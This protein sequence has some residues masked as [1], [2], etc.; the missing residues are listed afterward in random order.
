ME[1][2][3]LQKV[4]ENAGGFAVL[5]DFYA[6]AEMYSLV[7]MRFHRHLDKSGRPYVE[8]CYHVANALR[9]YGMTLQA[10]GCGH[11]LIEDTH[12]TYQEL[13]SMGFS[14]EIVDGIR[15]VT[16]VPGESKEEYRAK[17]ISN[18]RAIL[19]KIEDID[20]NSDLRRLKG[21]RPKDF[22]RHVEYM[23]FSHILQVAA[24]ER[25]LYGKYRIV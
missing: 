18:D 24:K 2:E 22:E 17:V 13:Y 3:E 12:T 10:I 16:K 20:H 5:A 19:V 25:N 8:H 9:P 4:A 11:D 6:L 21:V 7:A 1:T 23:E 15:C 14:D